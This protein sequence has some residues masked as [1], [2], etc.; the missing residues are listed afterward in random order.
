LPAAVWSRYRDVSNGREGWQRALRDWNV[1]V[2]AL[3]PRQQGPL[4][5][6]MSADSGWRR[7]YRDRD[8]SI[9]VAR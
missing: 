6:R 7:V 9:F 3:S 5:E 4:I 2:A 8:G 1:R